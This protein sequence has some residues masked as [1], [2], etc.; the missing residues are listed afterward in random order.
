LT[1][2]GFATFGNVYVRQ[3]IAYVEGGKRGGR[4]GISPLSPEMKMCILLTA[5]YISY[6][7]N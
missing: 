1:F 5:P 2:A 4:G 6:G 3:R 7:T